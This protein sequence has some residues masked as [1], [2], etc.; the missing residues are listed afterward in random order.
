MD[1]TQIVAARDG[2]VIADVV[3]ATVEMMGVREQEMYARGR[4]SIETP[5]GEQMDGFGEVDA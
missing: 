1:N 2:R 5:F 4:E 3:R